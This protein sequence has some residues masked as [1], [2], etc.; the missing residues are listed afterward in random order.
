MVS[1]KQSFKLYDVVNK[2]FKNEEDSKT[3][4]FEIEEIMD[5]KIDSKMIDFA[6]RQDIAELKFATNRDIAEL[7][8]AT[9]QD[10]A[11][12]KETTQRNIAELKE[13]TQRDIAGIKADFVALRIDFEVLRADFAT[14]RADVEKGFKDQLRW[15]IVLMLGFSSMIITVIKF[16]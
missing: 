12:L 4:V 10:I 15:I 11:E 5:D 16:L 2:Y 13:T 9:Q 8:A 6:T 14:L 1:I 3:V 7:K